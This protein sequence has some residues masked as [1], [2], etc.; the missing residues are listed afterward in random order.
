MLIYVNVEESKYNY[1]GKTVR[2]EER[3]DWHI[4]D[5]KRFS[6]NFSMRT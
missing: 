1:E 3:N 5:T 4:M 6:Q 2:Y